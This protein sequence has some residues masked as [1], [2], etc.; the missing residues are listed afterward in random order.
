VVRV[1]V[2]VRANPNPNPNPNPN[3]LADL[4]LLEH[5]LLLLLVRLLRGLGDGGQQPL[6]QHLRL[7]LARR[8]LHLELEVRTHVAVEAVELEHGVALVDLVRRQLLHLRAALLQCQAHLG[9][10]R[11]MRLPR[12]EARAVLDG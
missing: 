11:E 12:L 5:V 2:R 4:L 10:L 7:L 9:K 6:E 1:R 3:H 8:P